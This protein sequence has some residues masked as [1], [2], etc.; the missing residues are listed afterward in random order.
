M[1]KTIRRARSITLHDWGL[2][3]QIGTP[4]PPGTPVGKLGTSTLEEMRQAKDVPMLRPGE[5]FEQFRR[6]LL[7][8]LRRSRAKARK[9]KLSRSRKVARREPSK[10]RRA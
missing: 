8:D 9:R 2:E 10:R 7:A 5:L 6:Q 1:H 3:M 4:A